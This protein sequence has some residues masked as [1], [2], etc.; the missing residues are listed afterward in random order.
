M[1]DEEKLSRRF[2]ILN[3]CVTIILAAAIF[4]S[5]A[6]FGT[7]A[8]Q[9]RLQVALIIPGE[10]TQPGWNKSQYNALK[11]VCG[12]SDYELILRE[13]VPRDY[14]SCQKVI[15]ELS[16]RGINTFCFANGALLSDLAK[17]EKQNPKLSLCTVET[18]SILYTSGRNV[19]L[20][21]EGYYIA[22]ILAGLHTKTNKIGYIAPFPNS[23]MNM[24]INAFVLGVQRV[25]PEA[26]VLLNWTGNW[27]NPAREEQSV[28]TLKAERVDILTYHQNGETIPRTAE[29]LGINFISFNESYPNSAHCLAAIK[30]DWTTV[31]SDLLRYRNTAYGK[32]L[33]RASGV[34]S[35][36]VKFEEIN[37]ISAREKVLIETALRE[38][39]NG[40]IIFSGDIFDR[41]GFRRCAANEAVSFQSMEQNMNWLAKGVRVVGQ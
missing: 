12:E 38:I 29:R 3:A 22:G 17:F 13:N 37:K 39:M 16:A 33:I 40:R 28:Q 5:I 1:S 23:E 6:Q 35:G 34:A 21:F 26:E 10:K 8:G 2:Y 31:Y 7:Q 11:T 14:D 9:S 32:N 27:D 24:G 4:I 18:V 20:S 25:N 19:I 30:I 36:V 15:N 41:N